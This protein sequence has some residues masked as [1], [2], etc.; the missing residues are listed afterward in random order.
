MSMSQR[1]EYLSAIEKARIQFPN[2]KLL[3]AFE[4]EADETLFSYFKEE[5][6]GRLQTDYL[7]AGVHY[8]KKNGE[9]AGSLSE[10]NDL[11]SLKEF[12]RLTITAIES[13]IFKFIA[14][15][16]LFGAGYLEWDQNTIS[17]SRDILEAAQSM[18]MPLEINGLGFWKNKIMTPDGERHM[19]PL[20]KFWELASEYNIEVIA[21]LRRTSPK[22]DYK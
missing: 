2:L 18:K 5:L 11:D 8:F 13:K 21:K 22:A 1:D 7:I 12:T 10:L 19:Y 14:H 9:W 20:E 16:D 6:L 3:K 4:C 17:C 15:P